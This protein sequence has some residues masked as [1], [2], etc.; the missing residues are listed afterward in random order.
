MLKS[1][2]QGTDVFGHQIKFTINGGNGS[3]QTSKIGG[4]TTLLIYGLILTYVGIKIDKMNQTK[5]KI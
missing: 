5:Q 1:I 2:L 3:E 4:I